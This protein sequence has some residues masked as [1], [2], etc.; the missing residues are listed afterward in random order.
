MKPL[1]MKGLFMHAWDLQD[2]GVDRLMQWIEDTGLDTM[3]LAS[4]YHSGWFIHPHS[5]GHRL[6]WSES[7]VAYFHPE[8]SFYERT[9]LRPAVASIAQ[10]THWL[11]LV[12]DR[13]DH[14]GLRLVS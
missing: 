2:V 8:E 5:T 3:C 4:T 10:R 9:K 12:A 6:H 14:H 13:L 7:G 11:Q 1:S